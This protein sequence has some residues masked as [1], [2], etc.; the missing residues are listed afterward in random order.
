MPKELV[1]IAPRKPILRE[2]KD[3][4]LRP[5]EVRIRSMF[6]SS[7]H[8]TEMRN[9]RADTLDSKASFDPERRIY[10]EGSPHSSNFPVSLGNMTVGVV[11]EIGKGVT[12]FQKEDK[13]FGHLSIRETHIV[14]ESCEGLFPV[15][16]GMSPEAI[17]YSDPAGV[18]LQTVRDARLCIG[19]KVAI[20]GLGAIGQMAVQIARLQ[21]ARWIA[22]SDPISL[23]REAAVQHGADLS[24]N[25]M[26]E[27]I[28]LIIKEKTG[29]I[30]VDVSLETSG[31]YA[32]LNDALRATGYGGTIV[33]CA[34][35]NIGD[36]K[37]LRLEG[38]WHRN[39]L[40]LIS[41]RDVSEPLRDYPLW[42]TRRIHAEVFELLKEGRL[43]VEGLV[44]P[45]V[46]FSEV[47]EAYREIDEAPEKSIKLG[48]IYPE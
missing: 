19:D 7:K 1:A 10:M 48:I 5:G 32:A 20:F 25:P 29:K 39:R 12:R 37:N 24:L 31:A 45:I 14:S 11:I 2:Y 17:I 46:P 41:S 23:R 18:A 43:S 16:E 15:P 8:G 4:L 42:D 38:E 3:R 22:V 34:F 9:Y 36:A 47:V 30:G 35:Y 21:G 40:T 13:I 28:G 6:S 44:T 27:D 33:S 26:Q